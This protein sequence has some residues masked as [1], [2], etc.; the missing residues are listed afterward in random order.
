MNN[1]W[2]NINIITMY[3]QSF[4]QKENTSMLNDVENVHPISVL[5]MKN[6]IFYLNTFKAKGNIL[7]KKL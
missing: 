7:C 1:D 5:C 4:F 2:N 6:D 3:N